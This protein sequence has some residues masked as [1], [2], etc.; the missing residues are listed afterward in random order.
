VAAVAHSSPSSTCVD[1]HRFGHGEHAPALDRR[2]DFYVAGV[3][4][5]ADFPV[6]PDAIQPTF[7]GGEIDGWIAKVTLGRR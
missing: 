6:T 4:S 3:T 2:G 7:G 5:S 1:W